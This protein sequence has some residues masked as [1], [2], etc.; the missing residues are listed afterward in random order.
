MVQRYKEASIEP[1]PLDL[2]ATADAVRQRLQLSDAMRLAAFG[3]S[4]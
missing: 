4:R 1:M 2:A 3:K